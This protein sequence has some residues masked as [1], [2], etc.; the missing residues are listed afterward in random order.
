MLAVS[1]ALVKLLAMAWI[2]A[3]FHS[4]MVAF[5]ALVSVVLHIGF[6]QRR[7]LASAVVVLKEQ[8]VSAACF[9]WIDRILEPI[10]FCLLFYHTTNQH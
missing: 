9:S 10:L 4:K 3:C 5:F 7:Q 8:R 2:P 6:L 1:A